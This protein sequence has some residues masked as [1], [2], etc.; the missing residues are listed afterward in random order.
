MCNSLSPSATKGVNKSQAGFMQQEVRESL[1]HCQEE[2]REKEH[3]C[4]GRSCTANSMRRSR[5]LRS[6]Q[7]QEAIKG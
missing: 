4:K 5:A 1:H 3:S 6:R 7:I 2:L